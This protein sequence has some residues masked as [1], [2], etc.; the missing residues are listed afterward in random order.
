MIDL[1]SYPAVRTALFVRIQVDEYRITPSGSYT[2]EVLTFSDHNASY[3]INSEVYTALGN[4]MNV[5]A[6][7]NELRPSS[8]TVS[9]TLSGIPNTSIGEIVNSKIKSSPVIIYRGFFNP[10]TGAVIGTPQGRFRGFVN[11]YALQEEY[12][13]DDR[14]AMNTLVIECASSV[15]VLNNKFSGR[16]TNPQSM[17]SYYPTDVAFDRVPNLEN[18]TFNFG[19][20]S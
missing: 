9:I 17:K 13:V 15:D 5:T 3:S 12:S 19:A 11:N 7:S 2:S 6:S 18:T 1:S 16:K 4:L 8:N 20:P 14:S 10:T